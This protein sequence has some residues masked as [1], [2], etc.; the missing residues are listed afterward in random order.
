MGREYGKPEDAEFTIDTINT[1]NVEGY[2][3]IE[4]L[5]KLTN[6]WEDEYQTYIDSEVECEVSMSVQQYKDTEELRNLIQDY[7]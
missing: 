7:E 1:E 2:V 3:P 5:K 4:E 6:R